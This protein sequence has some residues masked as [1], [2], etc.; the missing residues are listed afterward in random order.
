MKPAIENGMDGTGTHTYIHTI[1]TFKKR[2]ASTDRDRKSKARRDKN[3][4][5]GIYVCKSLSKARRDRTRTGKTIQGKKSK[6]TYNC[7]KVL[8][9]MRFD[10]VHAASNNHFFSIRH[11]TASQQPHTC[12]SHLNLLRH[13]VRDTPRSD[14]LFDAFV[15]F[16]LADFTGA[17]PVICEESG[18]SYH[19]DNKGQE[20]YETSETTYHEMT[21]IPKN[22]V[23]MLNTNA[24][25]PFGVNPSGSG[26][27]GSGTPVRS[28]KSTSLPA[29]LPT[30]GRFCALQTS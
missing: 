12:N 16:L 20:M 22:A 7:P 3:K 24:T 17:V 19:N 8:C 6:P 4:L 13:V 29:A 9:Y 5:V 21:A 30:M 26:P 18:V 25:I 1:K 11:L 14:G 15:G 27:G 2:R 10:R 23:K 28:R